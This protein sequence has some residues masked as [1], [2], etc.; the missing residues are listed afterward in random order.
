MEKSFFRRCVELYVLFFKIG[1]VTF[2]GGM[3]MLPILNRELVQKRGW[4]TE[5]EMLDYYAIGQSTPGII[6]VN[7]ATFIGYKQ[8]GI[9]GGIAATAG[10]VSPSLIIIMA[11][12]SSLANFAHIPMVKKALGGINVA[13]AA[14]LASAVWDFGRKAVKNIPGAVLLAGA[15]TAMYVFKAP[16]IAVILVGA[17]AGIVMGAAKKRAPGT[18]GSTGGEK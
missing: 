7:V 2:G 3:A 14:L 13:V 4:A 11:L 18:D 8:G 16:S 17:A 12:A 15:F 1:G 5:E 10:M 6:A 9:L